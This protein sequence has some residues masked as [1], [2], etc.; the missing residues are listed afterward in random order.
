[1]VLSR[2]GSNRHLFS[3]FAFARAF[4]LR[5]AKSE[6]EI[7]SSD[8]MSNIGFRSMNNPSAPSSFRSVRSLSSVLFAVAGSI[9][10]LAY[11]VVSSV[12]V[13][14][15]P[16]AL[17]ASAVGTAMV[18]TEHQAHA[19]RARMRMGGGG[20][21]QQT[22]QIRARSIDDYA[23]IL[24]LSEEQKEGAKALFDG[25]RETAKAAAS[26]LE[27]AMERAQED[28]ADG[29]ME[30]FGKTM[31]AA[32]REAMKKTDDAEKQFYDEMKLLLDD[33]QLEKWPA[34][35][36]HRRREI[37]MRFGFVSGAAVDVADIAARSGADMNTEEMKTLV[38]SYQN[39]VDRHLIEAK[40]FGDEMRKQMEDE[41]A[42]M[43]QMQ[44][45]GMQALEDM[46]KPYRS[47]RDVNLDYRNRIAQLMTEEQR[48]KFEKMVNQR[49]FGRIYKEPHAIKQLEA[50]LK[51]EGVKP[52]QKDQ[53]TALKTQWQSESNKLNKDWVDATIAAEDEKGGAIQVM[54]AG[55]G[56]GMGGMG[57][58][59]D[60]EKMK[61]LNSA[62][63]ARRDL[64][65]KM[66]DRLKEILAKDQIS[67][68]P[69][70]EPTG[71]DPF[72]EMFGGGDD[73]EE[74]SE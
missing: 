56:G 64:E 47:L 36:R 67:Q 62:R 55:F 71:N 16:V 34:I 44:A 11:S 12:A 41:N 18:A 9:G 70:R 52:E 50:A 33:K 66:A 19:Q 5:S 54:I 57:G 3:L 7:L 29:N 45:L 22:P 43:R 25:Y 60:D 61:A 27:A 10:A 74:A 49:A 21:G 65:K 24:G 2:R 51:L 15:A 37:F 72:A 48:A 14:L 59:G 8:A 26:E 4:A 20:M 28:I 39:D 17:T 6:R 13:S 32:N 73:E 58:G 42:D 35:E 38:E 63:D 40:R 46:G 23:K 69:K 53:L 1:M 30:G 68:L 31:M